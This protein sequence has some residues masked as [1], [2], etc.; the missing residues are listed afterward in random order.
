MDVLVLVHTVRFFIP[1]KEFS[2]N[3]ESPFNFTHEIGLFSSQGK[4][5]QRR[6]RKGELSKDLLLFPSCR[7][8]HLL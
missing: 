8:F 4:K 6:M 1:L 3:P 7:S 2:V 5:Y